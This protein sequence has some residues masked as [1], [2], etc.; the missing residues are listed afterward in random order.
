MSQSDLLKNWKK[1]TKPV[2]A[3]PRKPPE[4]PARA[5]EGQQRL[6]LLQQLYPDNPFYQYAHR[7]SF[8]GEVDGD[9]LEASLRE[10]V[11]RHELL[12]SNFREEEGELRLFP[13][14]TRVFTL[15]RYDLSA[16]PPGEKPAELSRVVNKLT[17]PF[18]LS[19][20]PLLRAALMRLGET[21]Y[22]LLL[23]I[24][25]IVGDR[26]SLLRLEREV[27]TRYAN[28]LQEPDPPLAAP[29]PLQYADFTHWE[30]TRATDDRHL[31][32]WKERLAAPL[33][34][35]AL[36]YDHTPPA[37]PS[38]RGRLL[39]AGLPSDVAANI[40]RV[41]R[42]HGTTPN[43]VFLAG[44]FA[45]LYRYTGQDDLLIGSPV[46]LRDHAELEPLIGFFN[47]TVVLRSGLGPEI[48]FVHLVE[49]T[50]DR[51]EEALAHR[52]LPF[53][54]LT[55]E[56]QPDRNPATNPFFRVMFVYN[57]APDRPDYALPFT[58]DDEYVDLGTAKFD[59]TLFVTNRG[60]DFDLGFEYATDLFQ[61]ETIEKMAI[62]FQRLLAA[63]VNAPATSVATADYLQDV[64][65]ELLLKAYNPGFPVPAGTPPPGLLPELFLQHARANPA[66]TAITDGK[67]SLTYGELEVQS[68]QLAQ[69]LVA[70][71][72]SPG[73]PVGLY[74]DRRPELLVGI[75]GVQRAGGAY[76]PLDPEYPAERTA[77]I[78][79]DAGIRIVVHTG[80]LPSNF[81]DS[82][83]AVAVTGQ[84]DDESVSL[85]EPAADRP[86]YLIYTSGSTGRPKGTVISHG[87]L[88]RSTAARLTFYD[89]HPGVFLLL[90]SFA[91]DS[92]V[93][94]IFWTMAS[95]GTLVLS[96][97]RTE[98]D[99]AGLGRLI[100]QTGVSHTL[101]LPS[102]YQLIL[103][104]C[105]AED[106]AS[107][108]VVMVAGEV[109]PPALVGRHFAALPGTELVNEYGPTEATVWST[110]HRFQPGEAGQRVPIGRPVPGV[111]HYVVDPNLQLLPP[112]LSGE[113]CLSGAQL[114]QGYH[115]RPELTAERFLPNPFDPGTRLYRTGD[116]VRYRPE[117]VLDFLGRRDQQLKIR[118]HRIEPGEVN[119]ALEALPAV[120]E[121]VTVAHSRNEELELVS[122]YRPSDG[123]T[124]GT[125]EI[126]AAL[127]SRLPAYMVPTQLLQLTDF[128]RLPNGKVDRAALPPPASDGPSV[129]E[130]Y[131]PPVGEV[132]EQL[133]NVWAQTLK[134][135]RIGRH[136]NFFEIGGDSLRSIRLI[137]L[138]GKAGLPIRAQDLFAN[139]T[140]AGLAA[141]LSEPSSAGS[142]N[143][144]EA[145]VLLRPGGDRTPLFCLHSGG[146]HVVFYR[147]LAEALS[148]DRPVYALQ[149]KGLDGQGELP[150]SME[151]MAAD[152]ISAI[153]D[154]QPHG[155]YLLLGSCFSNALAVEM[156][157]Q[158]REAGEELLP[159]LIVDSGTGTFMRPDDDLDTGSKLTN[160]WRML[161][162]GR[163][164]KIAR[165]LRVRGILGYRDVA[166]RFDEQRRNLYGTIGALNEMYAAYEWPAYPGRVLLIRSSEF[167]GRRDKDHHVSRWRALAAEVDVTVTEG[168]HLTLF[169]PPAVE[170]LA[171]AIDDRL[172]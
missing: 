88:A 101:M 114:A 144:Y 142:E 77:Y 72:V 146:G 137:A 25:H 12:R 17:R 60:K 169:E 75:L 100:R 113:L 129:G 14:P 2:A 92:S 43:V 21:E 147:A 80:N 32:Y 163:W 97:H 152:Y 44:L 78:V 132:E 172:A 3:F 125:A 86:A 40:S 123:S 28:W 69:R 118:G 161:R 96:G 93:A 138:A 145:A 130:E 127:R 94:G 84:A 110:A 47:E 165:R 170:G 39:T 112:G 74:S 61:E 81:P 73:E 42:E 154:V 8:S 158:L 27:F 133:A 36:P 45:L 117:G 46:S 76:V 58:I 155:P 35:L 49:Q 126:I 37:A 134:L 106:L 5:G 85:P 124:T 19:A 166:S 156:A 164:D 149:P 151:E 160:L 95:G 119:S 10:T 159:L 66:A 148:E 15:E 150:G 65:R 29:L 34:V 102:L 121:A 53:S 120:A 20:E 52:H 22:Q 13:R 70:A 139:P 48:T 4:A 135:E 111:G 24:H 30:A 57:A 55:A 116:L 68:L 62:H 91:F 82:V 122:Y 108:A 6:Y 7:Y 56:L 9:L 141:A 171:R 168:Y 16:L 136:D 153:R 115:G 143:D 71:G 99:P 89:R 67:D 26:G 50:R 54:R 107:L 109:C 128:P 167:A 51:M 105:P 79:A 87:N 1:R 83:T 31:T 33:P 18:D 103:E 157:T 59:L 11:D 63:L 64:E 131:A 162:R 98:Q 90:S 38:Y 140:V 23:S 41:A 104:F